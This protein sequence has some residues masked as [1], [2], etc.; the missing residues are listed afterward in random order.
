MPQQAWQPNHLSFPPDTRQTERSINA[1]CEQYSGAE[2]GMKTIDVVIGTRP[3]AVKMA[4][5]IKALSNRKWARV[6][7]VL[8]GQ[9][10][11]LLDD[12]LSSLGIT[13]HVNLKL[14]THNQ[15]LEALTARIIT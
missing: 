13:P 7:V 12:A 5:V 3:E 6:R 15:T 8:T 14:M 11:K 9:H 1:C 4:P 2:D 10:S